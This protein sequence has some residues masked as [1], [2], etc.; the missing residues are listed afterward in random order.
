MCRSIIIPA[1]DVSFPWTNKI[2]VRLACSFSFLY[3]K[4]HKQSS[5]NQREREKQ[6]SEIKWKWQKRSNGSGGR[7][8]L[9]GREERTSLVLTTLQPLL[10]PWCP[11]KIVRS[12]IKFSHKTTLVGSSGCASSYRVNAP[13]E[14]CAKGINQPF[15]TGNMQSTAKVGQ[16]IM[17]GKR[18]A[19][20]LKKHLE[21]LLFLWPIGCPVI[22]EKVGQVPFTF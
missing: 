4:K 20:S 16:V 22:L 14:K 7:W 10:P 15:G 21:T 6:E 2:D 9:R 5:Q 18:L 17:E 8:N 1:N 11:A 19:F 13:R 12:K 3:L